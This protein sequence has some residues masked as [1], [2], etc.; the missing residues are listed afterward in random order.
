MYSRSKRLSLLLQWCR[1]VCAHYGLKIDNFTVS[2][3]DGRILCC[4][5]HHYHPSLMP[6]GKLNMETTLTYQDDP[7]NQGEPYDS[8]DSFTSWNDK[9]SQSRFMGFNVD[10]ILIRAPI[11]I[12]FRRWGKALSHRTLS[13]LES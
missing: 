13:C 3:S 8:D 6:L 9:F 2:F 4:L 7:A 5:L 11:L 12:S 10:P 1:A